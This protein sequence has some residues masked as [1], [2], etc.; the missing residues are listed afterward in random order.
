MTPCIY[1]LEPIGTDGALEA[2]KVNWFCSEACR[3]Q[4][5]VVP[6]QSI[7]ATNEDW[8][9]GTVCDTCGRPLEGR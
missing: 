7:E 1:T 8:I 3:V 2:T 4:F 6:H 5:P 9:E